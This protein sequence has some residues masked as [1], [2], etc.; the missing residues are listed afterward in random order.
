MEIDSF[1]LGKRIREI[2][3]QRGLTLIQVAE[4]IGVSQGF[5]SRVENAKVAPSLENLLALGA[6]LQWD[7][8][9]LL[10]GSSN[11]GASSEEEIKV[12]SLWRKL[13]SRDRGVLMYILD[14]LN[15]KEAVILR[16]AD[17]T[18]EQEA[19]KAKAFN[20]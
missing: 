13:T 15:H 2:R 11:G 19:E 16:L 1:A 6:L 3:K 4:Q 5:L 9:Y 14:R 12:L 10:T 20:L 17:E 18:E 8:N 7:W